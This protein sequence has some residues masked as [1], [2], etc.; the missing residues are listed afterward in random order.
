M[1]VSQRNLVIVLTHGLRSDAVG[2]SQSWPL[3][4]P[5]MEKLAASGVRVVASSACTAD[6]GGMVSLFTG[7][8][9]RQH[10]FT[11][12]TKQATACAGWPAALIDA[13][14]RVVGVGRVAS[15]EPWLTEAVLVDD[16]ASLES[17]RCRYLMEMRIRGQFNALQQQRRQRQRFGPFEPDRLLLEPDQDI[18][19]F[20][21]T[22]ARRLLLEMPED[23]PWALIVA[24]TGPANELP[25]PTLYDGIVDP[26]S[27]EHGFTPVDFTQ[28]NALVE[29]DYPR[30]MLQRLE[31]Q[32]IGR[33]RADYLGRVSVI[34]YGLGRLVSAVESRN[35]RSR[36]WFTLTSDRGYVLGEHGLVGHRS[37]LAGAVEV[38]FIL[39]PPIG[40][41][42]APN[43]DQYP[44]GLYSTVDFAPTI[45]SLAGCD[46]PGRGT[47]VGRSL[48][49]LIAGEDVH[50]TLPGGCLSEFGKRLMLETERYKLVI[51]VEAH[52]PIG[53][54]DLLNDSLEK[55]NLVDTAVGRNVLDALKLRLSDALLPLRA[56]PG[57]VG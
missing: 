42:P 29:L 21:A 20:I 10:G 12:T 34:D 1:A 57:G 16:V 4:T 35:D 47:S 19:G 32:K 41:R 56:T 26:A 55:S 15:I 9:A 38:P 49:P 54:Y 8:H 6:D 39:T 11:E 52:K 30:I 2:D 13:G 22:E 3:S 28:M 5:H 24:F 53:L 48:V 17:V 18:D 23:K 14:Y 44:A 43:R 46:A 37:F 27:L 50:P 40:T 51:D 33:I 25:P 7:L 31:P 36:T 45:A